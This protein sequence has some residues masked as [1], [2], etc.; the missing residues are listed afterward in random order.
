MELSLQSLIFIS[1]DDACLHQLL[2]WWWA[3]GDFPCV[4]Y[5][6]QL[7]TY[8]KNTITRAFPSPHL[9]MYL[10]MVF[11]PDGLGDSSFYLTCSNPLLLLFDAWIAW[12]HFILMTTGWCYQ[13]HPVFHLQSCSCICRALLPDSQPSL[14][15]QHLSVRCSCW[16]DRSPH[17]SVTKPWFSNLPSKPHVKGPVGQKEAWLPRYEAAQSGG[18]AGAC[19]LICEVGP[20]TGMSVDMLP[21]E[22]LAQTTF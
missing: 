3:N 14:S 21:Q 7:P 13:R 9:G 16:G 2:L 18:K 6:S 12:S 20:F 10:F 11:W 4:S 5:T 22:L 15:L 1:F 17:S 19:Y 8:C